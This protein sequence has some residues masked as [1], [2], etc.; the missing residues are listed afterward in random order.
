M[1]NFNLR[2]V[3]PIFMIGVL[4]AIYYDFV[5]KKREFEIKVESYDLPKH[6]SL[7]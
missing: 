4:T 3:D 7:N 2:A 1:R 5:A 6:K